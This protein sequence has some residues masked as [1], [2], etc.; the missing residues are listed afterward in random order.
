MKLISK[1][2]R[3]IYGKR[4]VQDMI[5]FESVPDLSDNTKA[6]FDEFIRREFNEHYKMIWLVERIDAKYPKIRNVKYVKNNSD[7]SLYWKM[8]R[9][10][11]GL[12]AKCFISCNRCWIKEREEQCSIYLTH[13]TPIKSVKKF[14]SVPQSIDYT[15]VASENVKQLYAYEKAIDV[16]KI[17]ALGYP[18]NDELMKKADIKK[19][20]NVEC[21]KV[22]VWYPTYRQNKHKNGIRTN[23]NALP[24]ISDEKKALE[25]NQCAV[26]NK[27][28]IVLK[29]H[30][31]QDLSYIKKLN[32]S[33]IVFIG[34]DFF[35]N[36]NISSYTFVGNC[37]ALLTDYSSVYYDFTLCDKPI[38][39]IW[40]DIEEYRQCPGFAVDLNYY[41]K[42]AI[43]IYTLEQYKT[44]IVDVFNNVD[45]LK[46]ERNE[47]KMFV[48][49]ATDGKNS[50]RVVDCI[51]EKA[52][53]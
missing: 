24:I 42:G 53:L 47:I 15:F 27:T 21:E 36:N 18:R 19:L 9:L 33:N 5:V 28:L 13:G 43:K 3:K 34:D 48:N 16:K 1:V 30:F 35:V 51:I 10:K 6:V 44:F 23:S 31:A 39:V 22:I 20:F 4:P 14:Y 32:L 2:I 49:Y 26:E 46:E 25:L 50:K 29:P 37:D 38:G 45:Y 17:F 40:E 7:K 41:M 11:I 52:N 12:Q 8:I